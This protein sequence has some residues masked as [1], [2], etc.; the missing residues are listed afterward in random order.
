M[1]LIGADSANLE[2]SFYELG[3]NYQPFQADNRPDSSSSDEFFIDGSS[4]KEE[5]DSYLAEMPISGKSEKVIIT[6]F[7]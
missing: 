3:D 2:L 4:N 1:D 5:Y 7:N 6:L